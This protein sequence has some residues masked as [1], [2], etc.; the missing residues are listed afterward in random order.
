MRQKSKF[1]VE[2]GLQANSVSPNFFGQTL[3]FGT[4]KL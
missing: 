1:L 4:W 2:H 3:K